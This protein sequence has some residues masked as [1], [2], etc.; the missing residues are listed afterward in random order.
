MWPSGYTSERWDKSS[1]AI[2]TVELE[3]RVA[4]LEAQL[5]RRNY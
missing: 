3:R 2:K 4:E 5:S 1:N